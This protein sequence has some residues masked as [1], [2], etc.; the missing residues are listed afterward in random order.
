MYS[1]GRIDTKHAYIK[2]SRRTKSRTLF[3]GN[4]IESVNKQPSIEVFGK[5]DSN[6]T[7]N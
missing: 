1:T 6:I 2:V 7:R 4:V 3:S 5:F